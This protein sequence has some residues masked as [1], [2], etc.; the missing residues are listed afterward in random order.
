ME[1]AKTTTISARLPSWASIPLVFLGLPLISL[2]F[3]SE[4]KA[5]AGHHHAQ[6][7]PPVIAAYPVT[8]RA[9]EGDDDLQ[10]TI[11]GEQFDRLEAY[12]HQNFQINQMI[13]EPNLHARGR[14]LL[15][16]ASDNGTFGVWYGD[17]WDRFV[18]FGF[19]KQKTLV[20]ITN[21]PRQVTSPDVGLVVTTP[22]YPIRVEWISSRLLRI[23]HGPQG[24][25]TTVLRFDEASGTWSSLDGTSPAGTVVAPPVSSGSASRDS[26]ASVRSR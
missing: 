2:L 18:A 4:E 23:A 22:G 5:W 12:F 19:K 26:R 16:R 20:K 3:G 25:V 21:D 7:S 14:V 17:C 15:A 6:P 13:G 8:F 11:A 9:G 10:V 24:C 1:H